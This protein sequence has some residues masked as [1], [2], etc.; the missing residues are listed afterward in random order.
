MNLARNRLDG[1]EVAR[2]RDRE[3]GLDHVNAKPRELVRDLDLLLLVERDPRRLL[4]VAQRGV[5]DLYVIWCAVVHAVPFHCLPL[6]L[7][8]LVS[9]LQRPPRNIPPE[10]GGAEG[11]EGRAG[12]A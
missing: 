6:C 7:L 4:A 12:T 8:A 9:R 3:A 1:L 10:G 11:G 2:R 5:E